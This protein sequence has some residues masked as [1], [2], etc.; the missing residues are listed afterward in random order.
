[1]ATVRA[2]TSFATAAGSIAAGQ[3]VDASHPLAVQFPTLFAA[4][5]PVAKKAAPAKKAAAKKAAPRA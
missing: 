2:R 3:V 1:M 5:D 4:V